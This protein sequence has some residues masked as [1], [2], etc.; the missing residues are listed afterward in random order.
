MANNDIHIDYLC[1]EPFWK[2]TKVGKHEYCKVCKHKIADFTNL[3]KQTTIDAIHEAGGETC[4]IF[5]EDQFVIDNSTQV[6]PSFATL[7]FASTLVASVAIDAN[8]QT[9]KSDSVKSEQFSE[10]NSVQLAYPQREDILLEC[11]TNIAKEK[12]V[13]SSNTKRKHRIN[14][15]KYRIYFNSRFPFIHISK[16]RRGRIKYSVCF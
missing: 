9:S 16:A 14:I 7:I 8:A 11:S 6:G 15:G 12:S 2:F 1:N 5:Y 10:Y 13:S 4:G 3:D